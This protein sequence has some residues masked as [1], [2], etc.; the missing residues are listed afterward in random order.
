[1][2]LSNRKL[3]RSNSHLVLL[4][5]SV[6]LLAVD[7]LIV[8]GVDKGDSHPIVCK[9]V[10][11]ML[12]Y[13]LLVAFSWMLVEAVVQYLK[14]VKVFNTYTSKFMMKTAVPAYGRSSSV[15]SS[16]DCIVELGNSLLGMQL[17]DRLHVVVTKCMFS[18]RDLVQ[19]RTSQSRRYIYG[20]YKGLPE[21]THAFK[22][23]S[24][25]WPLLQRR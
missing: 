4:H 17:M 21:P 3:K 22:V 14:F 5:L 20:L 23:R 7:V 12:L 25:Q 11:A 19:S 1:M 24:L 15:N 16:A 18:A 6:S 2:L 10:A 9:S 13:F 8:G